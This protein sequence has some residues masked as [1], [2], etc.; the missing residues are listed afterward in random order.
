MSAV[1]LS[2]ILMWSRDQEGQKKKKKKKEL[3]N[4]VKGK[5]ER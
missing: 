2:L 3:K 4:T 5:L 1:Y